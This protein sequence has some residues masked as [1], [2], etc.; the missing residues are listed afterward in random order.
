[1]NSTE[2]APLPEATSLDIKR[3]LEYLPHR[4]P[5]VMIDRITEFRGTDELV[6]RKC[7]TINEPYFVGHFPSNPVMP[8]VLQVEAM[9]QAAGILLIRKL[10]LGRTLALFMSADKVK[11]RKAVVPGDV[12]EIEVKLTKVRGKIGVAEGVCRVDGKEVSSAELMF[13]LVDKT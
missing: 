5:F 9:A 11:F 3:L 8:G 6:A 12:L 7:V 1:M 4:Y 2:P 13:T 10:N